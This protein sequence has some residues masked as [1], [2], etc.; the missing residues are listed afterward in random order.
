[1]ENIFNLQNKLILITGASSGIGKQ[2]ARVLAHHGARLILVGRNK[3]KLES[4]LRLLPDHDHIMETFDLNDI[5][6][7]SKW[8]KSL[9]NRI[10]SPL[11]GI[12]HSA[13]A[14]ATIPIRMLNTKNISD[15]FDVNLFAGLSLLKGFSAK[16]N[17]AENASFV[18][19]SSVMGV[20]GQP[21]VIS[22]AASK[23][24]IN[25]AVK[26]AA[27]ELANFGLRVNSV[28]PGVVET[29]MWGQLM[30]S[31]PNE[32]IDI[33]RKKHP[34]GL[35]KPDDVANAI[36]FLLTDASR[37][38]TGTNLVVDGGYTCQ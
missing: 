20:V 21:G 30:D 36:C 15:V 28:V 22:Y 31:V 18:F 16:T 34:L 10:G 38:I 33:I 23:G 8:L 4:T 37:W 14:H 7:I 27:L 29:E 3:E 19:L 17:F 2:T 35:G 1:M 32:Q 9:V 11:N 25:A 26:S 24:A 12:V 13:G 5:D 6:G